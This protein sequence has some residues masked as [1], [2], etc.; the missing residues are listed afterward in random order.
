MGVI[1]YN[2]Y[3]SENV[4][5]MCIHILRQAHLSLYQNKI[6]KIIVVNNQ[7]INEVKH[8]NYVS[9]F[10]FIG[11]FNFVKHVNHLVEREKENQF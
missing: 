7:L 2:I 4:H 1:L 3:N 6:D 11:N 5:I 9:V 10:H 8:K